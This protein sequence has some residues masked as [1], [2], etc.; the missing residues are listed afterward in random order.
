[1]NTPRIPRLYNECVTLRMAGPLD[2]SSFERSFTEVIRRHEILRTRYEIRNGRLVQCECHVLPDE[3][4][5]PVID[6]RDLPAAMQEEEV[7]RVIG[8]V[9]RQ[10]F[11]LENGPLVRARLTRMAEFEHRLYLIVHLSIIDGVSAYQIFPLELAALYRAYCS[12]QSSPLPPL[13]VVRRLCAL[14]TTVVANRGTH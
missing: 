14:A 1:M 10:P 5:P 9:V 2:I 11:D 13:A 3:I 7:K 8:E 12:G 6:L 4:L